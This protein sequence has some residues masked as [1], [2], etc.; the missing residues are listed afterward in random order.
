ME[1]VVSVSAL[2]WYWVIETLARSQQVGVTPLL[3]ELVSKAPPSSGD[4]AKKAREALALRCLED[5]FGP[6]DESRDDAV[7]NHQSG[8][9]FDLGERCDDVLERILR[10]TSSSDPRKD[11]SDKLKSDVRSFIGCKKASFPRSTL[12]LL[13]NA[14]VEG[15][16][17]LAASLK[18]ISGV[19]LG[20]H[21]VVSIPFGGGD[22]TS[23]S[24]TIGENGHGNE[25]ILPQGPNYSA[26]PGTADEPAHPELPNGDS[27]HSKRDTS[28]F[29]IDNHVSDTDDTSPDLENHG[30]PAKKLK[31]N[32]AEDE[33]SHQFPKSNRGNLSCAETINVE[34]HDQSRIE[35]DNDE[36]HSP[37]IDLQT[38]I[39]FLS[40]QCAFSEDSLPMAD[41]EINLCMKCNKGG[42]LLICNASSC[43][44]AFHESCLGCSAS[45][46]DQGDFYCPICAY[47]QAI[48]EYVIAKK[49][50][51]VARRELSLFIGGR[52]SYLPE[53]GSKRPLED[54]DV[55]QQVQDA[56]VNYTAD[57]NNHA[58]LVTQ[59]ANR[60]QLRSKEGKDQNFLAPSAPL[61][62]PKDHA[63][64]LTQVANRGQLRT[65]KDKDQ[66]FLASY[67]PLSEPKDHA[68]VLAQVANPRQLRST[69]GK[70]KNANVVNQVASPRQLRSSKGKEQPSSYLDEPKNGANV[71]TQVAN[72]RQLKSSKG[73]NAPNHI[74]SKD[75]QGA[76]IMIQLARDMNGMQNQERDDHEQERKEDNPEHQ[77]T[78][79]QGEASSESISDSDGHSEDEK[80]KDTTSL[81][82]PKPL[83]TIPASHRRKK[84]PWTAEEEAML[85]KGVQAF[86]QEGSKI[87][88]WKDI[89]EYGGSVFL[90][91]RTAVDLKDKWRNIMFPSHKKRRRNIIGVVSPKV[92]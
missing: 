59:V 90:Q 42:Q 10:E 33:Q 7:T 3:C 39:S 9:E 11:A 44:L 35:P 52:G 12:E 16:H 5:L 68:N 65:T 18:E 54:K 15:T 63:N 41:T 67:A 22:P 88:P 24:S 87:I 91:G 28:T 78:E 50:A 75:R 85:K 64:V 43:P 49:K 77:V 27:L 8:N 19:A 60:S 76:E 34:N 26:R 71:V 45:F 29:C 48:S 80:R 1:E 89:L 62:K 30:P 2:P 13:K 20:N 37:N 61:S 86:V 17:P 53:N 66:N 56:D 84:V 92:K 47:S 32:D 70:D 46:N 36:P 51:S 82:S 40:S 6:Y 57:Q 79:L 21:C 73:K 58:N 83:S 38:K 55:N 69:K 14:I 81:A 72:R 74:S 31:L 4:S 25:T 23:P